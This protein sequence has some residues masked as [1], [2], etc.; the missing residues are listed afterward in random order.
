MGLVLVSRLF[1]NNRS[2]RPC[3]E[4]EAPPQQRARRLEG[5]DSGQWPSTEGQL[6]CRRGGVV[7][8]CCEIVLPTEEGHDSQFCS[9]GPRTECGLE[10]AEGQ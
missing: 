1:G 7:L 2:E 3:G 10:G 4:G 8:Q 9:V 5:A 6:W